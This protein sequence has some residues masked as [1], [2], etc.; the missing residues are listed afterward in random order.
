MVPTSCLDVTCT[1][2]GCFSLH[3]REFKTRF[4]QEEIVPDSRRI[5]NVLVPNWFCRLYTSGQ[6]RNKNYPVLVVSLEILNPE[7]KVGPLNPKT[8]E[9]GEFCRVNDFFSNKDIFPPAI[10]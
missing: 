5:R 7:S 4:I 9:S 2:R 6:I 3:I 1:L 8:C 10:F